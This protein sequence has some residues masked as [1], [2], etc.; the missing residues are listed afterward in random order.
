MNKFFN[1]VLLIVLSASLTLTLSACQ[2]IVAAPSVDEVPD[3]ENFAT[4]GLNEFTVT[5][6]EYSF[7]G[8][9]SIP[10]GWTRITFDNQG[11]LAH[12]LILLK[13]AE[14]KT[15]D[16]VMTALEAEGPPEWA[17]FYGSVWSVKAGQQ[18]WLAA[19]LVPGEYV[20][21]SFGE[22]EDAPP[23]AAQGMIGSLAVAE[24]V[25][26]VA[27]NPPIEEDLSIDLINFQFVIDGDINAG[28]HVLRIH[29]SGDQLHE[30][31]FAK[32]KEG[33]TFED[34]QAAL[35]LEM[36]GEATHDGMEEPVEYVG[37]AFLS[38][39]IVNYVPQTFEPGEYIFICHLPSP[40]HDMKAHYELG[41][42]R[43]MTIK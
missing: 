8:P 20:Y 6:T 42:I 5:A 27:V 9:E 41:M 1:S 4:A 14:G 40:A 19:N 17:E 28:E 13:L 29:N 7:E 2:P 35:E 22:A 31:V 24:T 10:A 38:P 25:S 23:D 3:A 33:K 21:L 43:Q 39:G 12:D 15:V 16:D 18:T 32:L 11:E 34:F 37:G 36:S 26:P 30:I